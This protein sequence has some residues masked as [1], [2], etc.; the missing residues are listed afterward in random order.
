MRLRCL[1]CEVLARP[2]Y[3][4][5]AYSPHVVD[6]E[7]FRRGLHN[8]PSDLRAQL[9]A[10]IDA[11]SGKSYDAIVLAY[12]LCGQS[13]AG[14]VARD[15]PL[16]VPRAHDCITIFLGSRARYRQQFEQYP[17]TYW[18]NLDYMERS[19]GTGGSVALGSD[20]SVD[21]DAVYQEYVEKYGKENADYLM[22]VMGAWQQHYQRAAFID[23]GV[24]DA[25]KVEAQARAQAERRGWL[26]DRLAGDLALVRK[27][28][29]GE[30]DDDFLIVPPG[31]RIQMTYDE[32]VVT[33]TWEGE[34]RQRTT[35]DEEQA[36]G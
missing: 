28:L 30:W 31:Q 17:G 9:Q 25:S 8:N 35:G 2:L 29:Y 11:T 5:A 26:F 4:C 19:D 13:V 16:V 1:A 34:D 27:L 24:G 15:I 22:E 3:L 20:A 7:L 32:Q 12:G 6:V 23:M 18:Y 36:Y 10:R 14:L 21:P 33:C